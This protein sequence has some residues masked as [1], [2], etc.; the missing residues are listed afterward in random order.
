MKRIMFI[1]WDMSILGGINQVLVGLANKL[2]KDYE[3]YIVSLVKSGEKTKYI[4][5]SEI[6]GLEYLTE[7]D[8]RGREVLIKG[9]KK[10]RKLIK[11]KEIDILFLMGFQV[12]LP[13]ILMTFGL[14]CKN[15]FCDHE[16]LLSRWHE[17]KITMV[18]YMTS[19]FS[20][21]VIT[22]TKQNAED[23]KE[24]FRLSDKK[25]DFIYNSITEEVLNNCS[26]YNSDSKIILSVG[27]FSKEKGYDILVEVARKVLGKHED[28]KWYIYGNG[29]TFFEI[30]QQIKKEKLDKQVILKGE[31]SDVSSIYGQAGIFVLTSYREGLPLVLLEAKANHLPCV[32]FDIISGPKEIIRDKVDGILVPPYDREKMAETIEKL[33]CDTSLRKKMAEKAEENLSKFS[34]KEIMKQ[35]KQLIE[36]L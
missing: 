8:C 7:E 32:S 26:E 12:S 14:K 13:V 19:I 27:R 9:R 4:L 33:I 21:K 22:L 31:V 18:R 34:E 24:K 1:S 16:A 17:K 35:W 28:W 2:S 29:D 25:V 20:K 10:L 5:N 23:Y 30:E 6:K 15:V 3:V 11:E 36:E